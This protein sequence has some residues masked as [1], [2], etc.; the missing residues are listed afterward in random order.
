[1][2]K[3]L[4][5]LI[6]LLAVSVVVFLGYKGFGWE[7]SF[8]TVFGSSLPWQEESKREAWTTFQNYLEFARTHN[9]SG[10][11]SLSHQISATCS[12]QSREEECF[13]LMDSVHAFASQLEFGEFKHIQMDER[14]II[15]FTDG[16]T[17]AILYFTRDNNGAPK[18]LGLRFCLE[19]EAVL[20]SCVE[21]DPA[22]RDRDGNGWWDSVESLFYH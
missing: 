12:D 14:Q 11:R 19:D 17:V 20:D 21:T 8:Q 22:K 13:A 2:K 1:M 16:P 10:I 18:V 9:L 15:M 7:N 4:G 3:Q 6:P 5:V